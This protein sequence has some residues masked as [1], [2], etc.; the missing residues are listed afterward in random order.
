[1]SLLWLD[2]YRF[3]LCPDRVLFTH[4]KR[5]VRSRVDSKATWAADRGNGTPLPWRAALDALGRNLLAVK[6]PIP[7]A[8]FVLSSHFCHYA[9]LKK[10][11]GLTG[12]DE[13]LAYARHRM[14][15]TFG[16][17]VGDWSMKLSDA[18][19]KSGYIASAVDGALLEAIH[20]LCREK[21]LHLV[22][23]R[24]YLAVAFNLC[25]KALQDHTAWFVVHEDDR[26]VVSLF[27]A[28]KWASIASRRV[29]PH[30]K[31]ELFDVL[32]RE[33]QLLEVEG[34][35]C[36]EVLLYAPQLPHANDFRRSRYQV[37]LIR[38]DSPR[39]LGD[40]EYAMAA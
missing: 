20:V 5:F 28:G 19:E 21:N 18:G 29:G 32:D 17:A 1:M 24:P 9:L 23:I 13:L 39:M 31:T 14:K 38:P 36:R 6:K 3:A 40:G 26:L 11:E 37:E 25:R 2:H 12:H 33:Q 10:S 7:R 22:S 16:D 8:S 15:A 34:A 35:D 4:R 30:W 27:N